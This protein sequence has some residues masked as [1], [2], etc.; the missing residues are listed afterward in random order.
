MNRQTKFLSF[1]KT[2]EVP[3]NAK[4]LTPYEHAFV[5]GTPVM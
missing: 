2:D 5:K 3:G 4:A 1:M